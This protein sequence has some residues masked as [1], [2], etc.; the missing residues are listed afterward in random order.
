MLQDQHRLIVESL[1]EVLKRE[2]RPIAS[3]ID[4]EDSFPEDAMA[5]LGKAGY[6]GTLLPEPH[7]A[8]SD[9]LSYA[10]TVERVAAV[11]P[12]LAWAVVVHVSAA[13][14]I[15]SAGNDEQKERL[16]PSLSTGERLASFAFTEANAGADFF[17]IEC[18]ARAAGNEYRVDGTKAFIS[19]ASRADLFVTL[20]AAERGGER[21]GPS[22]LV[23]EREASGFST[24]TT[25]RGMG[26]RGIAWGELV[27]TGCRVP[28]GNLLGQEGKGTRVVFGMAGPYLL[29]AAALALGI[30]SGAYE[31]TRSHLQERMVKDKPIGGFEALQ[32]RMADLSAKVEAARSLVYRA[33][34]ERDARSVL[35]FQAKL[36]AS[37]TALDVT[38]SAV[39]LG[40]ATGYT[41]GSYI[42]RL[43]RDAFAVT[44][45]FENNDFLRRFLGGMLVR[46]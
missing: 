15:A 21:M 45:H 43:A 3:R 5:A 42:E 33:C 32:F 14:A 39:Q 23:I 1:E 35:P 19:L 6:L 22:M 40:G 12:S 25:L 13:M 20:V 8:G 11:S 44:L 41:E 37:E 16:L 38:R 9:L 29:G 7:G 31:S 4:A 34:L 26:M 28:A 27:F 10:L 46:S 18:A 17:A 30:A 36:F 2:V 24:G